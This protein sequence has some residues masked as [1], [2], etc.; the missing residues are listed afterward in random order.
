MPVDGRAP[1]AADASAPSRWRT[2]TRS[3]RRLTALCGD[4][5]CARRPAAVLL[6]V[7]GHVPVR[8]R[9]RRDLHRPAGRWRCRPGPDAGIDA[10]G[11]VGTKRAVSSSWMTWL[12]TSPRMTCCLRPGPRRVLAEDRRHVARP[13]GRVPAGIRP[14][15]LADAALAPASSAPRSEGDAR[16]RF[17]RPTRESNDRGRR[18]PTSPPTRGWSSPVRSTPPCSRCAAAWWPIARRLWIRRMV[19]RAWLVLA[20]VV[21]AELI[22]WTSRGSCPCRGRHWSV[23]RS[24]SSALSSCSAWSSGLAHRWARR[25]WPWTPKAVWATAC[26]PP[27]SSRSGSR[28]RP[29]RPSTTRR[30]L[31]TRPRRHDLR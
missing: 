23:R 1:G 21:V 17:R 2:S 26:R 29:V 7:P 22:L 14:A 4:E 16:M 24:R 9:H 13:V 10:S 31:T 6:P 20:A 11:R 18:R 5:L 25:R 27:S 19:R 3:S 15:G 8:L 12:P 30:W 28:H